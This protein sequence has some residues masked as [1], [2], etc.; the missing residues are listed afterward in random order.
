M[1]AKNSLGVIILLLSFSL[2]N[3]LFAQKEGIYLTNNAY[4]SC[5]ISFSKKGNERYKF[6]L[7][8]FF[9]SNTIKIIIG[10]SSFHLCKDSIWGYRDD[11]NISYRLY[12]KKAYQIINPQEPILLYSTVTLVNSKGNQTTTNYFFSTSSGSAIFPLTKLNLKRAYPSYSNFHELIDMY[13]D[14]DLELTSYDTF[15]K[16]YKISRI[17]QLK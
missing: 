3:F 10:D 17:Y 1:K 15:Y 5:N 4:D 2:N 11:E 8:E 12:N 13:F 14:N 9:N 6:K 7:N 16:I